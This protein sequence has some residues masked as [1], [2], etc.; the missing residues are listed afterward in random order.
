MVQK[1]L[2]VENAE[3]RFRNFSGKETEYN[4]NGTREFTIF[5]DEKKAEE[6]ED[7][8]WAIRW[9][10]PVNEG[11]ERKGKLRVTVR[12]D[13]Y[14]PKIMLISGKSQTYLDEESVGIIDTAELE[15]V[16]LVIR[17]YNWTVNG[18]SGTK[19]YLDSGYFT[20]IEDELA[21]KYSSNNEQQETEV[22][23]DDVPF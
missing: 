14:P 12:F 6:L 16:D 23:D 22:D 10:E 11:D 2:V 4:R 18:K 1:K 9:R 7:L 21:K 3:I 20:I 5:F 15:N 8:G 19:A 13:N 17:P